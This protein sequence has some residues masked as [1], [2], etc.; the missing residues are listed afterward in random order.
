MKIIII[1]GAYG[2]PDENWFPWLKTELER[3]GHKVFI[4]TFPTPEGQDLENWLKSFQEYKEYLDEDTILVGHSLG[5]A[6]IL[7]VLERIDKPIKAAFFVAGFIGLLNNTEFDKINKTFVNKQFN[8]NKI[9]TN[10]KNFF[11][12][13]SD[14][15]PYVPLNKTDE[16]S[17]RLGIRTILVNKAGHFNAAAGYTKFQ[18]LLD[19]VLRIS[20]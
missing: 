11:T 18:R 14:N 8:W 10:C 5:P 4:P 13:A 15:D 1:H 19:D 12:Y 7:T 2:N 9:R 16:L 3:A 6:L 20:R 17:E